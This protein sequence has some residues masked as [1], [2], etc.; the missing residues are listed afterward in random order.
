MANTKSALK[1]IKQNEK[2]RLRNKSIKTRV[3]GVIKMTRLA[4]EKNAK[5]E[6]VTKLVEAQSTIDIALK[7]G[8]LHKQTASR[9]ISR[10]AKLVNKISA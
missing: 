6:A 9:T 4:A 8:V 5:E 7:K 3:R 2:R 1:R 10:L